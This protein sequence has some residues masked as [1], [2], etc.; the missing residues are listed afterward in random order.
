MSRSF[1]GNAKVFKVPHTVERPFSCDDW[2]SRTMCTCTGD[3]SSRKWQRKV[4]R[5]NCGDSCG[6][7]QIRASQGALSECRIKVRSSFYCLL[8]AT[9][10]TAQ[11]STRIEGPQESK[12]VAACASSSAVTFNR[13]V[14]VRSTLAGSPGNGTDLDLRSSDMGLEKRISVV[15]Q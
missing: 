14:A 2:R 13:K 4:Y 8:Q 3:S 15:F 10:N 9:P 7:N 6:R 5:R 1:V 12:M 11:I